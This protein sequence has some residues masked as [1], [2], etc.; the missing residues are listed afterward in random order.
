MQATSKKINAHTYEVTIK[1]SAAE[2]D[3]FRK[4][5]AKK[6]AEARQFP[7]FR[8]GDEVPADVVAREIGE[9]RLMGEAL[10][11]ALQHI[12]PK[13]LKKLEIVP[14]DVGE[15]TKITS[16]KPLEV[17]LSVEVMPEVKIDFKKL[18]KIKVEVPDVSVSDEDLQKEFDE[19]KIGRAHV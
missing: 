18:E 2:M 5:A 15:I 19:I 4:S 6:I 16:M 9:D 14:V 11:E 17:I 7:G 10:E 12:Y 1:E 3:H 8:K 13:A